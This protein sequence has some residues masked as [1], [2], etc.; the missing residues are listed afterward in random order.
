MWPDETTERCKSAGDDA[1]RLGIGQRP[2]LVENV[3]VAPRDRESAWAANCGNWPTS[4]PSVSA[5]LRSG[6][7]PRSHDRESQVLPPPRLPQTEP[8]RTVPRPEI[9]HIEGDSSDPGNLRLLCHTCP[10]EAAVSDAVTSTPEPK[11][12]LMPSP[13]K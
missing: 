5:F 2:L 11:Q 4:K 1:R 3:A 9:N 10:A 12:T 7:I 13:T 6:S 8:F